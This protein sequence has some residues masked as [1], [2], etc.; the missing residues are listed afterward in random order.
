MAIIR[1]TSADGTWLLIG[2]AIYIG[3]AFILWPIHPVLS[4]AW[5]ILA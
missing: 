2:C 1:K 3:V 5:L 4:I